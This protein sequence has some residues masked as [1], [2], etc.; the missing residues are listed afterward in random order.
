MN[1]EALN[2]LLITAD[3]WRGDA[4]GI[5]GHPAART[6][7]LDAMAAEAVHFARHYG[8]ATPCGPARASLHTGQYAFNHRSITNGTPLDRRHTTMALEARRA[9][10]DPVLF[11]YTDTSADPRFLA[12][13]DPR[14]RTYEGVLPGYRPGLLML[15]DAAPWLDHLAGRGLGRMTL[16]EAY[17]HPLG[18]AAPWRSE[19]SETAFLT[20]AFL[21]WLEGQPA[22]RP[23]FA[24]LSLIKPHPP[25]VA[26]SPWH[27][28]ID[29]AVIPRPIRAATPEAEAALHPWLAQE[30]A[31]SYDKSFLGMGIHGAPDLDR[32]TVAAWRRVYLGLVAEVDHHLG[33]V[34]AALRR[35]T[36]WERTLVIV[37]SDHGEMLG[38]HWM[39][40]K[41]G[42]FPQAF[43]V[44]LLLRDP[45]HA[46]RHGRRVE[47]FTQHVDLLPTVLEAIGVP[48]PLQADGHALTD[49]LA[50]DDPAGWRESVTW[51]HD[52]RD[53]A[54]GLAAKALGLAQEDC[55]IAVR[56]G[57]STAY[58][59]FS[60]LPPLWFDL[61]RD[62]GW[63]PG[64]GR[65]DETAA[66]ML[67]DAQAMLSHRM[68]HA[69][70]RLASARLTPDGLVGSYDPL[71]SS[72]S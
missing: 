47:A 63:L 12:P 30:L 34:L 67:A 66:T 49:F 9:G 58:V 42:F 11:G 43:H 54:G 13:D 64:R 59:H 56:L 38:D 21:G 35:S 36:A 57:R 6:P 68:R 40:G 5:A 27:E 48:V 22:K 24:H 26:A 50:G 71:P 16:E 55:G 62:P 51:E 14:L 69:D 3:Q 45:R 4:L 28:L 18:E 15:E 25:Y 7:N 39:V 60:G 70:R 17:A 32:I 2:V 37:T 31:R 1:G 8:Q 46:A 33:R 52:F 10:Y 65:A 44:P 29:P 41:S 23:W 19:D 72:A 61:A 20:D 53:M